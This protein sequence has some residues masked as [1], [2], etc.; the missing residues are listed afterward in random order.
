MIDS[1]ERLPASIR[2]KQLTLNYNNSLSGAL[3]NMPGS[4]IPSAVGILVDMNT[5]KVIWHKQADKKVAIA[6][7]SKIMTLFLA[8]QTTQYKKSGITMQSP[9]ICGKKVLQIPPTKVNLQPDEVFT[10]EELM[11]AAAI[12]SANDAAHQIA[13][14]MGNGDADVFVERMNR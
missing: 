12:K 1:G 7:M 2:L 10:L 6:S 3:R 5:G 14:F 8:Y 11:K 13:E 4:K 9:V